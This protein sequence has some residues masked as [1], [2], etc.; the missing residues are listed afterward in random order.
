MST[1]KPDALLDAVDRSNRPVGKVWRSEV[2]RQNANF[3]TVHILIVCNSRYVVLQQL[4]YDHPRSP[5]RLGS[6]VAGYVLANETYDAAAQRKLQEELH[7]RGRLEDYGTIAMRDHQSEK[8]VKLFGMTLPY[9]PTYFD[10]TQIER[11][12]YWSFPMIDN[13]L[14]KMPDVFTKTFIEVYGYYKNAIR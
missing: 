3:R 2:F 1:A 12:R 5:R 6:S 4:P 13:A 8:F 10:P 11:L 7:I 14:S 9:A